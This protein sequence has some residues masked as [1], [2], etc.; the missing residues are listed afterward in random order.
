LRPRDVHELIP[1]VVADD[2][3]V[4]VMRT[5]KIS[6]DNSWPRF[7]AMFDPSA[8]AFPPFVDAVPPLSDAALKPM[9]AGSG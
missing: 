5:R 3:G 6:A 7:Q 4:D 9:L 2:Q 8:A 1:V